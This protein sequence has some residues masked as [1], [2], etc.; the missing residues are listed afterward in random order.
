MSTGPV[1][2]VV[3]IDGVLFA[4]SAA[5]LS[6]YDRGFVYG[7]AIFEVVRTYRGVPFALDEHFARMRRSAERVLLDLPWDFAAFGEEIARGLAAA[8]NAESY[9]RIIVTRGSGPLSLDPD[10]AGP[11]LRVVLVEPLVMPPRRTYVSGIAAA[12]IPTRRTTDQTAAT[13]AKVTN[14]LES[15]LAVR[16]AKAGGAEEALIVDSS[17]DVIEGATS[18]VFVA[19]GG[20]VATPPESAGILAG[21]TRAHV[22]EVASAA[23]IVVSEERLRPDDLYGADEVFL[24]SSVRELVPIVRVDGRTICTGVP[25][26]VTRWLHRAFRVAVGL[27]NEPMPWES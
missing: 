21:I 20:R 12:T 8:G 17:G 26:P 13:G 11:P 3:L 7:D 27:G 19:R 24:T 22:L 23:G 16:A 2:R 10:T 6:V 18:N 25:G 14:Y 15:L 9:L 1:G 4:P 5:K